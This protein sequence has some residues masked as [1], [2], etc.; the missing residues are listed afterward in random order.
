[1]V[2]IWVLLSFLAAHGWS[3]PSAYA[4][5]TNSHPMAR[6]GADADGWFGN[7]TMPESMVGA[8]PVALSI[9]PRNIWQ[10]TVTLCKLDL[11]ARRKD[12]A[13]M[14]MFRFWVSASRCGSDTKAGV[15]FQTTMLLGELRSFLERTE[16]DWV[17]RFAAKGV[18]GQRRGVWEPEGVVF[19]EARVGSTLVANM[20]QSVP[21]S[22]CYSEP[23]IPSDLLL[24]RDV[25]HDQDYF[26]A[27]RVLVRAMGR[28]PGLKHMFFKF[29]S[30]VSGGMD[31]FQKT[32]PDT[33]FVFLY[34]EPVEVMASLLG[35]YLDAMRSGKDTGSTVAHLTAPC[36]RTIRSP[37]NGMAAAVGATSDAELKRSSPEFY[38]AAHIGFI[39]HNAAA[40]L[41]TAHTSVSQSRGLG[42]G[43]AVDYKDLPG[44]VPRV[45]K[46]LYGVVLSDEDEVAV[47]KAADSYSKGTNPKAV[48]SVDPETGKFL[49][50][51]KKKQET[52][53]HSF[54]E[55]AD[56]F[57]MPQR[58]NVV[59]FT[60]DKAIAVRSAIN[61]KRVGR[62]PPSAEDLH[63][64]NSASRRANPSP[65]E[66]EGQQNGEMAGEFLLSGLKGSLLGLRMVK[67]GEEINLE[68]TVNPEP[69]PKLFP[70]VD[71][72]DKWNVD[73][74]KLPKDFDKFNSL[75]VFDF[76]NKDEV[77]QA[78]RYRRAEVPFVARGVPNL[79][80]LNR[81]WT[82]EFL[83]SKLQGLQ[84]HTEVSDSNHFM[85]YDRGNKDLRSGKYKPTTKDSSMTY[86]QW[87][88]KSREVETALLKEGK[89]N[90]E[91]THWY[92]RVTGQHAMPSRL[93]SVDRSPGSFVTEGFRIF[94]AT[95][96]NNGDE[97][98]IAKSG[99]F[100]VDPRGQHGIHCRFGQAGIVAEAHW[101]G[102]RNFITMVRGHKRYIL[103]PPSECENLSMMRS[104]PSARHSDA[105][106]GEPEDYRVKLKD[107]KAVEVVIHPGDALYVPSLWFHLPVSLDTSIQCNT[108]S[109]NPP[110]G[111][112]DITDC[113]FRIGVSE[114]GSVRGKTPVTTASVPEPTPAPQ[115]LVT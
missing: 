91:Q 73:D 77:Q 16:E 23:Q 89:S 5:I 44:V 74:P 8:V 11:E 113:G 20:L 111:A 62:I 26:D 56:K 112:Q 81:E 46:E 54:R 102:G 68:G 14:P 107:A 98:D 19:H 95:N 28:L 76:T 21:D 51:S 115:E 104:G 82:D 59:G 39:E 40:G 65:T 83:E 15:G 45:I 85:Y 88:A 31:V 55:A 24:R 75:R 18:D 33:P 84:M 105:K 9:N 3:V 80:R 87:I 4:A 36:T 106:W 29:Q 43:A 7:E 79:M 86:S 10:S 97:E 109:G 47:V 63:T 25:R 101:D 2:C 100:I 66:E 64:A 96:P 57:I 13:S 69:Y 17:W 27:L 108:R 93:R 110:E 67:D 52:A 78:I 114:G 34:R 71:L 92:F 72:L 103:S 60:L 12:P 30:A 94:D 50:D 61:A 90:R 99:F 35:T 48:Q 41:A 1:M 42:A 37:P 53:P 49:D 32:F 70:L 6:F 38:C 22:V 58:S